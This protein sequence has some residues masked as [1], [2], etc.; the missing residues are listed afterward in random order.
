MNDAE[1]KH[2]EAVKNLG[3]VVC[4]N[5]G[6]FTIRDAITADAHHITDVGRR[7]DHYHT[8]PL[9]HIHHRAGW[10]NEQVVSRH[11]WRKEFESRYGS[12]MKLLEQTKR[13]LDAQANG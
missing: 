7:I 9:C 2:L 5:L 13:E 10:N 3:C 8:I 11:P 1:H 6:Y 12:E 4:R